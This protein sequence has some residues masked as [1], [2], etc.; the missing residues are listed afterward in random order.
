MNGKE[1]VKNNAVFLCAFALA[2]MCCMFFA[3]THVYAQTMVAED[4][5]VDTTWTPEESPYIVA[6]AISVGAGATLTLLPGTVVKF[7]ASENQASLSVYGTFIAEGSDTQPIIFTSYTDDTVLG[8]TNNDGGATSP[9]TDLYDYSGILVEENANALFDHIALRYGEID[10]YTHTDVVVQ[11]VK[12]YVAG[13]ATLGGKVLVDD[14]VF[15]RAPFSALYVA[16][17]AEAQASNITSTNSLMDG[18]DVI[19][20]G[21]LTLTDATISNSA[22]CGIALKFESTAHVAGATI[23]G[24]AYGIRSWGPNTLDVKDSTIRNASTIGLYDSNGIFIEGKSAGKN[25]GEEMR[26]PQ[27]NQ[28]ELKE[29]IKGKS[30]LQH[31]PGSQADGGIITVTK[32]DITENKIGISLRN[33]STISITENAIHGNTMLGA[34]GASA[35]PDVQYAGNWWGD[36]SGPHDPTGNPDGLGDAVN[37]GVLYSPWLTE[38]PLLEAQEPETY[39]TK[40]ANIP[41]DVA[42]MR[43]TPTQSGVPIKTLPNGW[44]VQVVQKTESG[45]AVV[46]GGYRWYR[47]VDPTDGT[48]GWMIASLAGGEG[49]GES[50]GVVETMGATATYLPYDETMQDT[51]A[52]DSA[53]SLNDPTPTNNQIR[54]DT[55][56]EAVA[57]FLQNI[58]TIPSL[59]SSDD[60]PE[61]ISDLSGFA[62]EIILAIAAQESGNINFDNEFVT[63]DYGHGV[64]QP[65]M[66]AWKNEP[67]NF[68]FNNND[69][70][71]GFASNVHLLKCKSFDPNN[72]DPIYKGVADYKNCYKNTDTKNKLQKPYDNFAHDAANPKYKEYTNTIQSIYA[73]IK[74]GLGILRQKF[75]Y[76]GGSCPKPDQVIQGITFTC[77]DMQK[78]KSIWAYNG[79]GHD[80]VTGAYTGTYLKDVADKLEHI[81]NYFPG[82]SY[83]DSDHF[84]EKLR[85]ANDNKKTVKVYSPV[86]LYAKDTNGNVTGLFD[87]EVKNDIPN[88]V[89]DPTEEAL[90]IFFPESEPTYTVVGGSSGAYGFGYESTTDGNQ[91]I[92]GTG[93]E[94]ILPTTEAQ[95]DTF[96]IDDAVLGD[97]GKGINISVDENSDGVPERTIES[98]TAISLPYV[99]KGFKKALDVANPIISSRKLIPIVFAL[100]S[101]Y[102]VAVPNAHPTLSVSRTDTSEEYPVD[103]N[104]S[105]GDPR[106]DSDDACFVQK[107]N[108]YIYT[109]PKKALSIGEWK[110]TVTLDDGSI[111]EKLIT[112]TK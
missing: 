43:E 18:I 107:N 19:A 51:Y 56:T 73:N 97:G 90:A 108:K 31:V 25:T 39:Y 62:P 74:D 53:M 100:R 7:D 81:G 42:T 71:R 64:M 15:D 79:F 84:I 103:V 13:I 96:T 86:S 94:D 85:I 30:Q 54:R 26:L 102:S 106:C 2:Y 87:G 3:R 32:T 72:P 52:H 50:N 105:D 36:A 46:D 58:D 55:I 41:G 95:T 91:I 45:L 109:L 29:K 23:D 8:D 6:G 63:F 33:V 40:I 44:I 78:I 80:P 92:A 88:S 17:G 35:D 27:K 47:V 101:K 68:K 14:V 12:G 65:T 61:K 11:H 48:D 38:N 66:N 110:V 5:A 76:A 24:G 98:G 49:N 93:E 69:D 70:A 16:G 83:D 9:H 111:H 1:I 28:K 34:D 82:A 20:G 57:H 67:N 59:Y 22:Q 10:L 21:V 104:S 89:Y 37:V 77:E 112:I 75:G 99:F 4:I 60:S